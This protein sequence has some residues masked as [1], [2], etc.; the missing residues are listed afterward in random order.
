MKK[1]ILGQ[2]ELSIIQTDMAVMR[3]SDPDE[4][5]RLSEKIRTLEAKRDTVAGECANMSLA[6]G[7]LIQN[8]PQATPT[9]LQMPG[10]LPK[11]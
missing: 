11:P 1:D 9:P 5:R 8:P 3:T 6:I 7:N 10:S 2:L 4:R